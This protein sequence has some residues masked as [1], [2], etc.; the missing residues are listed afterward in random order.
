MIEK[1]GKETMK[2]RKMKIMA[3][4]SVM[5]IAGMVWAQGSLTPPGVPEPT[6]KTLDQ[7]DTA[8]DG[9]R[10]VVSQVKNAVA[11]V[12][13]TVSQVESDVAQVSNA[14]EEVEARIDLATVAGDATY[15]H[16]ISQPGSYYL[17]GNLAVT[18]NS[19][20]SITATNVTLDLNGFTISCSSGTGGY[21]IRAKGDEVALRNGHLSGFAQGVYAF[22]VDSLCLFNLTVSECSLCGIWAFGSGARIVD[23]IATRNSGIG[24]YVGYG[25]SLSGCTASYNQG[26]AG[27]YA[28]YGSSL[29]GCT[30]SYNQGY[31]GIATDAGSSLSGCTACY[32]EGFCGILAGYGSTLS[33]CAAYNNIGTLSPSS[34]IYAPQSTVIGCS[35]HS[36]SNTMPIS[37]ETGTGIYVTEGV[38]KDCTVRGNR[39]D[40]IRVGMDSLVSGNQC[41][42]NGNGGDGAGIHATGSDNRFENNAVTDNDRGI[43]V[44]GTGNIIVRNTASG[45]STNWTVVASNVCLVVQAATAGAISGDSGGTAPGS[46]DPNANF[47]Y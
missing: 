21:G 30:A 25:S 22:G 14:V 1:K 36:N 42:N 43:D 20:I 5:S 32:N 27:I 28:L 46:T 9:V 37:C 8:I 17:S 38:V 31:W 2:N 3:A 33:G 24:I 16:I 44:D 35:A 34:G 39:G 45:N 29:S 13:N 15:H 7:L 47:T 26:E 11:Q 19:G 18:K 41:S 10:N 12:S 4:L 40:G 6:M 23:C